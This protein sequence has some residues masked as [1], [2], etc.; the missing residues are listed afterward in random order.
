VSNAQ[1]A[2][3]TSLESNAQDIATLM[4]AQVQGTTSFDVKYLDTMQSIITGVTTANGYAETA[5]K[6]AVLAYSLSG[7]NT[8]VL[9]DA[10]VTA[11]Q[12]AVEDASISGLTSVE[13]VSVP[14]GIS[15]AISVYADTASALST[16]QT[17][18]TALRAE[19]NSSLTWNQINGVLGGLVDKNNMTING[20][21]AD[22]AHKDEIIGGIITDLSNINI[23]VEM[24]AGSGVY[25]NIASMC[26]NY[27]VSTTCT[28]EYEA[29]PV[30]VTAPVTMQTK[31]SNPSMK[32]A[33]SAIQTAGAPQD[34]Q[35]SM[36]A[37]SN[38]VLSDTYGYALDFGFRTNASDSELLLQ[39]AGAQRVYSDSTES[40]TQGSGSYMQFTTANTT[41]FS[42]DEVRALMSAIRVAFVS[43]TGS[44]TGGYTM[45]GLAA[46]DIEK[47]WDSTAGMYTY[48][49]GTISTT[50][51]PNDTLK[52]NLYLYNYTVDEAT[53]ELILG[54]MKD[55]QSAITALVPDV[56]KKVTA[57]VYLDGDLVDNT[58]VA[59]ANQSMSGSL[60][61]QFS[62]SATL[63]PM[64]NT[65]MRSGGLEATDTPTVVQQSKIAEAGET[66][67]FGGI[68]GTVKEGYVITKGS[69]GNYYYSKDNGQTYTKMTTTNATRCIQINTSEVVD[70]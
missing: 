15:S 31:A 55:D 60:N 3:R 33:I 11:L 56:A 39:T 62:S 24:N 6:N 42:V 52:A 68:T 19:N 28:V 61:L 44:E 20:S 51:L 40:N 48:D 21:P 43:P 35:E 54:D 64:E 47:D 14:S 32:T 38:V 16:A 29:L 65:G 4:I 41:T 13:G 50:T 18:L 17:N 1:I 59:N 8:S 23:N 69:D 34:T 25:Y 30:P 2:A 26:D 46:L 45:L 66:Y 36:A 37:E 58:M 7:A 53:N 57:I 22:S 63:Q 12:K 49:G 70:D 9:A 27:T 67:S 5:I 10:D